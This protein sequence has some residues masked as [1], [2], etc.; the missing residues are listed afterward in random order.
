MP[1]LLRTLAAPWRRMTTMSQGTLE[2]RFRALVDNAVSR[3]VG[4]I[5]RVLALTAA[6]LLI[7][8][9][10]LAAAI[11]MLAWPLLPVGGIV[12]II[13]GVVR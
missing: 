10:A 5:V 6:A 7:A 8:G 12:L 1:L 4:F 11:T 9:L 2:Q 13:Y 3:V